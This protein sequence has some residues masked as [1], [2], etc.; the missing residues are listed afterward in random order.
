MSDGQT[1]YKLIILY[2]L[3]KV[4]FPLTNAQITEFI[5]D[6]GYTDYFHVQ[7]AISDL[8]TSNLITV[9]TIRNTSQYQATQEGEQTLEYF[10]SSISDSIRHDI[11]VF[12]SENA[13]ELRNE[14]S[15]IADYDRTPNGDYAVRCRVKE[16]NATIIDLTVTVP[17]E[18]EAISMCN[19]WPI[20]SQEIYMTVISSLL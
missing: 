18:D 16:G 4:N 8:V 14:V 20:K 3:R 5:V 12:L 2:M 19:H 13:F 6:Q 1:L 7:E 10:C 9:E 11:D 17:T 15:T